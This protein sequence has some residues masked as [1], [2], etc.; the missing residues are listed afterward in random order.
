M[1]VDLQTNAVTFQLVYDY[2]LKDHLGNIRS[3]ITDDQRVDGYVDASLETATLNNEKL[4]YDNLD[5]GRIN[6]SLV[7]GYPSDTYTNPNGY[8]LPRKVSPPISC[9][10]EDFAPSKTITSFHFPR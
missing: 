9:L 3:T 6:K 4:Y 10:A 5:E 1:H 7:S 2:F 8:S